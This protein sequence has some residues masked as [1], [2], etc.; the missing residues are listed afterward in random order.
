GS[1]AYYFYDDGIPSY[2]ACS[3]YKGYNST[4]PDSWFCPA[5]ELN[6]SALNTGQ[7]GTQSTVYFSIG[8]AYTLFDTYAGSVF[9][10][11]GASG[12]ATDCGTQTSASQDTSCGLDYGFPFFIGRNV[13]IAYAG[14]PTAWGNGPYYAY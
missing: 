9:D 5:S 10:D 14:A 12:G 13:Y 2:S 3:S 8:N 6:L 1:N 11:L 7:N 4:N